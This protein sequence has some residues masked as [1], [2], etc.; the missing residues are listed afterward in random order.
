M[1]NGASRY[2]S[3][4]V[5][6]VGGGLAGLSAAALL[7]RAGRSVIVIEQAGRLGG[8]ACTHVRDDIHWNLGPHALYCAGHAFSLFKELGVPF[9]G[10]LPNPGRGLLVRGDTYFPLPSGLG[11]L[12]NTRLLTVREKWR[13]ARLLMK[14]AKFDT[15]RL[16]GVALQEWLDETIGRGNLAAVLSALFRLSTYCDDSARMSA[17]AA[18]DQLKLALA[19]NVWYL[20]GGWQTL[21]DGLRETAAARGAEIRNRARVDAVHSD[22]VGVTVRL[23]E[24]EELYARA[25]ILAVDPEKACDLLDVSVSSPLARWAS[26]AVPSRAAC[27][28]LALSRLSQPE[29]RFAL[30]LERPYYFS[31][32]SAAARLAPEG[33]AVVHVMKYLG[34]DTNASAQSVEHELE[35]FLVALQ[36][37]WKEHVVARRFLPSLTVAHSLPFAA[38]HGLPGRPGVAL[39]EHPHVFLAGD[40][41]GSAG[42]LA[43]ASAASA[44]ESVRRVLAILAGTPAVE[45]GRLHA[46]S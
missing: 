34:S 21:V 42:M 32:H 4:D 22:G 7:A 3:A 36:P 30:G 24:G 6:I 17:G 38:D 18:L 39:T 27:L 29:T 2:S 28:D 45:R 10:R 40:W 9:H 19:G 25:A 5:I 1:E 15:R 12:I 8:R 11:S 37:G 23:A 33:V 16:D 44:A 14:L 20:D 41:V 35:G 13:F 26:Q 43:D 46:T 31:V